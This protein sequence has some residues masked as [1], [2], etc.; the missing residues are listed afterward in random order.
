MK[1]GRC[2][3]FHFP[4]NGGAIL[5][6]GQNEGVDISQFSLWRR[7]AYGNANEP[8]EGLK[9]LAE[10]A[11]LVEKM[12]SA[13]PRPKMHRLRGMLLLSTNEHEATEDRLNQAFPLK[14]FI[15]ATSA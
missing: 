7:D 11:E 5:R 12:R 1:T 3:T 4:V 13:G 6:G 8:E 14:S 2:W 15:K 9:R 10:A